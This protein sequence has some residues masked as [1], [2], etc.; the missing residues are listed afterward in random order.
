MGNRLINRL[1]RHAG[2][3]I[4]R[5][6]PGKCL[7]E[8]LKHDA[9]LLGRQLLAGKGICEAAAAVKA[10]IGQRFALSDAAEA[11]R[12]LEARQTKGA[13]ILIP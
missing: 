10:Q 3:E 9:H 7:T 6:Q 2:Q 1:R 11:H 13:T 8:L 12:A 4:V 5:P